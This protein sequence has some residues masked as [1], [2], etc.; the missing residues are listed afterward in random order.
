[1]RRTLVI[2][3][4]IIVCL[5]FTSSMCFA[6]NKYIRTGATGSNNGSG[7]ANAYRSF[8]SV[9]WKRGN[10]YYLAGGTYNENVTIPLEESGASWIIIKKAN[11]ADNSGD[12][13]WDSA[14]ATTQAVI[15]GYTYI[16]YGYIEIDGVTGSGTSGHGIKFNMSTDPSISGI[17]WFA[18]TTP[19]PRYIHHVE[20]R[21]AGKANT[22]NGVDG[23][24]WN[25]GQANTKGLHISYCWVHE[26]TRSGITL[27]NAVG[28]SYSDYGA[29]IENNVI[30]ETGSSVP[31]IHGQ[32]LQVSYAAPNA[33]TIIRNN[34]FRNISGT[35]NIVFMDGSATTAATHSQSRIHNNVFYY[36]DLATY[37]TASPGV[38]VILPTTVE[39]WPIVTADSIFIYNNTFYNIG[40]ATYTYA[41]ARIWGLLGGTNIEVK[42]NLFVNS[43]FSSD[44][45]QITS[46]SNNDYYNNTGDG[47]PAGETNQK[48]ESADPFAN[49]AAYDFQL[50]SM[51]KAKNNGIDLSSVLST[52]ILGNP[53]YRGYGWDIGAYGY[54]KPKPP[55]N[56]R[57]R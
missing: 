2:R 27:G 23:I 21:G 50:K 10:T 36:T 39:G 30:S 57:I 9:V 41:L 33:Y 6:A 3:A 34:I 7:W 43:Y 18:N 16:Y 56:L 45:Y 52:D 37:G 47:V 11:A 17:L 29:L 49:A 44:H 35:G 54:N 8:A 38:I 13:G 31:A 42:N 1:M 26:T 14:Y 4:F 32:G 55:V 46:R 5:L 28:T 15:N 51:A 22:V 24:Y 20:V 48:T 19:S 40:S 25:S 12:A 53:R